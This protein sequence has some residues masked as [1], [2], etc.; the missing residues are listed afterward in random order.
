MA[1]GRPALLEARAAGLRYVYP[2]NIHGG[3]GDRENT[4]CP[5]CGALIIRRRGFY[6]EE[7]RMRRAGVCPECE[8][9]IA[10][11]WEEAAPKISNGLGVPRA[12]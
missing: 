7:N 11:V 1:T 2:G 8:G 4:N 10:G 6:V 9:A 12:V 5:A 3:V